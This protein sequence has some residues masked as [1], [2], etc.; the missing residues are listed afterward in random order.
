M[1]N[2]L[3]A[4]LSEFDNLKTISKIIKTLKDKISLDFYMKD[5]KIDCENTAL[6][7]SN[8]I[9]HFCDISLRKDGILMPNK[10]TL[11]KFKKAYN[12]KEAFCVIYP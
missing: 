6:Y 10:L 2:T 3:I 9:K 1:Y 12:Y 4:I 11:N 8:Y 5:L 7:I